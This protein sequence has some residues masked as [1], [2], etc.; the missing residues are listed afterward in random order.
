[1]D[2]VKAKLILQKIAASQLMLAQIEQEL[3]CFLGEDAVEYTQ[4][5]E[6]VLEVTESWLG[7][8][9][10]EYFAQTPYKKAGQ[11]YCC[12]KPLTKDGKVFHCE[13]CGSNYS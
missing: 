3:K 8:D 12:G 10:K 2:K 7:D 5:S 13:V 1:M 11:W 6:K 4:Q 9:G